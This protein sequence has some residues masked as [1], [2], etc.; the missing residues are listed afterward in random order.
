MEKEYVLIYMAVNIFALLVMGY[1]KRMAIKG[2]SRISE[3]FLISISVFGGALGTLLSMKAFR[4]K[5]LKPKF[6]IGVPVILTVQ[7]LICFLYLSR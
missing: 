1:D 2:N 7:M 5:T 4:H 6:R 3:R